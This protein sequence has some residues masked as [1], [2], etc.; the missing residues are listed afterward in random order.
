MSREKFLGNLVSE[1]YDKDPVKT[2]QILKKSYDDEWEQLNLAEE[3]DESQSEME[4]LIA[5]IIPEEEPFCSIAKATLK[6]EVTKTVQLVED[7]LFKRIPS[8]ELVM[9]G[10]LPGVQAAV[11][12]YDARWFFA[13][14]LLMAGDA[15]REA[16]K[17][18]LKGLE[19][20]DK[21]GLILMHAPAGDVHDIGKNIV[22]IVLE[23]N[24]FEVIDMGID[25]S[26]DKVVQAVKELKPVMITGS[27]LMTTTMAPFIQ[28]GK[29]LVEEGLTI[30]FAMGGAPVTKKWVEGIELGIY[31]KGPKQAVEMAMLAASGL[32]WREIRERLHA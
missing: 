26:T 19:K 9:K 21:R 23:A 8:Q 22:K 30:P 28:T 14:E 17:V 6:G 31:G 29:A 3:I 32:S 13:P 12:L 15:I 16:T 25:V 7:A 5:D 1:L 20:M 2:L 27:A 18:A 24:F 10:L 4:S 11:S